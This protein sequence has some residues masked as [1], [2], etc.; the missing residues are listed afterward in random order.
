LLVQYIKNLLGFNQNSN[1]TIRNSILFHLVYAWSLVWYAFWYALSLT[2]DSLDIWRPGLIHLSMAKRWV[3]V[4][5]IFSQVPFKCS[6]FFGQIITSAR[7]MDN[8]N[9]GTYRPGTYFGLKAKNKHSPV[10]GMM[11]YFP[12]TLQTGEQN[13]RYK[14]FY[15]TFVRI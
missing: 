7:F 5:Y 1:F 3:P 10:M 11:W 12:R 15:F 2:L 6:T 13:I 8:L 9:W 14:F 4:E